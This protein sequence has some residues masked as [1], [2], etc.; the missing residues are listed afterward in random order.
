MDI[1]Q[2]THL[3]SSEPFRCQNY[4]IPDN[5]KERL[6]KIKNTFISIGLTGFATLHT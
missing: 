4:Q 2:F 6:S 3:L 5:K 1:L